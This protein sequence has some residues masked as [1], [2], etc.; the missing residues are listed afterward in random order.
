MDFFYYSFLKPISRSLPDPSKRPE[1]RA[2]RP[3]AV[4]QR[5]SKGQLTPQRSADGYNG[6]L[7]TSF[8]LKPFIYLFLKA[9]E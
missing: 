9:G 8:L 1:L 4:Q 7:I 3:L 6:L 5:P 2:H